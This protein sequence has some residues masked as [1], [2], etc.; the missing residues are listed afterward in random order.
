MYVWHEIHGVYGGEIVGMVYWMN[1][2]PLSLSSHNRL[3]FYCRKSS[4][5]IWH[6]NCWSQYHSA[7]WGTEWS[8]VQIPWSTTSLS[9]T[10]LQQDGWLP[11]RSQLQVRRPMWV[12]GD[13]NDQPPLLWHIYIQ[14]LGI[15]SVIYITYFFVDTANDTFFQWSSSAKNSNIAG[16]NMPF[17]NSWLVSGQYRQEEIQARDC[18]QWEWLVS[19]TRQGKTRQ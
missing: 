15:Y 4:P 13:I 10:Y 1:L 9:I 5:T 19:H 3:S 2:R 8:T 11:C 7:K 18:S 12:E 17:H 6:W 16:I 14:V